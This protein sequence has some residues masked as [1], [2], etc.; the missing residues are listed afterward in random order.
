ME[1]AKKYI[2]EPCDFKCCKK[3]NYDA[4]LATRKHEILTNPNK[5]NAKNAL[6]FYCDC[7]KQYLRQH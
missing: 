4:H 2:C 7:G 6:L 5:K 3:S 1:N